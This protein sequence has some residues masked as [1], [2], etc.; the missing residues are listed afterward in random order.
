M[1]LLLGVH[2]TFTTINYAHIKNPSG[3]TEISIYNSNMFLELKLLN[4][5]MIREDT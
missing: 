4:E 3:L 5:K 2:G 1:F